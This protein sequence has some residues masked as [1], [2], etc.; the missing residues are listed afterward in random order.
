MVKLRNLSVFRPTGASIGDWGVTPLIMI[1][2]SLVLLRYASVVVLNDN[3]Q[4]EK[5]MKKD[6]SNDLCLFVSALIET[7]WAIGVS[8]VAGHLL[9]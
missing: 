9:T 4:K 1:F 5:P 7:S 3:R 6:Q 8:I 2:F